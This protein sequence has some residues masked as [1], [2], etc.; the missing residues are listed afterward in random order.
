MKKKKRVVLGEGYP[1]F[2]GFGPSGLY[3]EM[4][5]YK[6]PIAQNVLHVPADESDSIEIDPKNI[7]NSCRIRL[8]AEVIE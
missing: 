2:F 6:Y 4:R 8:I 3:A 7:D 1:W 5:L